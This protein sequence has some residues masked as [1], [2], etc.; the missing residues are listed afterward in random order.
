M[1]D[2]QDIDHLSAAIRAGDPKFDLTGDQ[3]TDLNDLFHLV[4]N[5]LGASIGDADL[6]RRFG[7]DDFSPTFRQGGSVTTTGQ[8]DLGR[9]RLELRR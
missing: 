6:D 8:F 1:V 9:R 4:R 2:V 3:S 5:I 7:S